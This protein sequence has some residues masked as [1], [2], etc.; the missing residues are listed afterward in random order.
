MLKRIS[1]AKII[2]NVIDIY[3]KWTHTPLCAL[4]CFWKGIWYNQSYGGNC[5]EDGS[6]WEQ[7]LFLSTYGMDS[8]VIDTEHDLSLRI[9]IATVKVF[10]YKIQRKK[11]SLDQR[12]IIRKRNNQILFICLR[13][14]YFPKNH[15][16]LW[17][18]MYPVMKGE[19]MLLGKMDIYLVELL[20]KGSKTTGFV[21][22]H[23]F[24][25]SF[26][27]NLFMRSR[28]LQVEAP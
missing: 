23:S 13:P 12:E 19:L 4:E 15:I 9:C 6:Q 11:L 5:W 22:G 24:P 14:T 16:H 20:D 25:S 8:S 3:S 28:E 18:W 7:P 10:L 2:Y 27:L 26:T 21:C 1:S 17:F